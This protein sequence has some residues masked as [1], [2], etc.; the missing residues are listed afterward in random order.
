LLAGAC[1]TRWPVRLL[2]LGLFTGAS[3]PPALQAGGRGSL[4]TVATLGVTVAIWLVSLAT[5]LVDHSALA[6]GAERRLHS[7]HVQLPTLALLFLS[8]LMFY[9]SGWWSGRKPDASLVT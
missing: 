9:S 4:W 1:H 8:L 7:R 6:R 3:L 5:W 2:A